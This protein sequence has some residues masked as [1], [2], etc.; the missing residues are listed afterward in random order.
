MT[1]ITSFQNTAFGIIKLMI[2]VNQGS[3]EDIS[4]LNTSHI[5]C[6]MF[7]VVTFSDIM[8]FGLDLRLSQHTCFIVTWTG[9]SRTNSAS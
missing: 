8:T 2:N 5:R 3:L 6:S 1:Y 4:S 9:Q 7:P